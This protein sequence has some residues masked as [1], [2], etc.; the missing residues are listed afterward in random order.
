MI[1]IIVLI[2]F[3]AGCSGETYESNVDQRLY[4]ECMRATPPVAF[5]G[6][7]NTQHIIWACERNSKIRSDE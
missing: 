3:L 6:G 4:R 7:S 2:V 5:D 1:K